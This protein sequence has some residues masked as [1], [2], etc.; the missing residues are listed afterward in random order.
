ML[1]YVF[2]RD[3]KIVPIVLRVRPVIG[4]YQKVLPFGD[5][6]S[7]RSDCRTGG[8]RIKGNNEFQTSR[9]DLLV[10]PGKRCLPHR[11]HVTCEAFG[12]LVALF[13]SGDDRQTYFD[14]VVRPNPEWSIL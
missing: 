13:C 14:L 8:W 3:R 1:L 5:R 12:H 7:V 2:E 4:R 11:E 10:P 9:N 6:F